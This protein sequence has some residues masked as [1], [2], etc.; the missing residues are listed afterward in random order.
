VEVVEPYVTSIEVVGQNLYF[1]CG[2]PFS[3]GEGSVKLIWVDGW[4]QNTHDYE[5][6]YS[7]YNAN[8]AGEYEIFIL[9]D[10]YQTSYT[11]SVMD[12]TY[13]ESVTVAGQ[14]T[15]FSLGQD[16]V[17][18]GT[19]TISYINDRPDDV[20]EAARY[21]V[22]ADAYKKDTAGTYEIVVS[23]CLSLI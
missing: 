11:V 16:F 2:T 10:G 6:D 7:N 12:E 8:V 18:M 21:E 15:R 17:F 14:K 20:V 23:V 3:F 13:I 9:C 4:K 1:D 22:N 19:V 5:V